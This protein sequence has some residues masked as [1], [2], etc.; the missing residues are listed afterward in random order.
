MPAERTCKCGSALAHALVT[1]P[2]MI[3]AA[4]KRKLAP[5]AGRYLKQ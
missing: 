3:P 1:N 4:T 2:K 5:I